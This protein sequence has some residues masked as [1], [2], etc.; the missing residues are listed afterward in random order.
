MR[1]NFKLSREIMW[2]YSR[3]MAAQTVTVTCTPGSDGVFTPD[4]CTVKE[5]SKGFIGSMFSGSRSAPVSAPNPLATTTASTSKG[6][7]GKK[8]SKSLFG[9]VFGSGSSTPGAS[10]TPKGKSGIGSFSLF[11]NKKSQQLVNEPNEDV[12]FGSVGS[13]PPRTPPKPESD[14]QSLFSS[15]GT[16]NTRDIALG[17]RPPSNVSGT[18]PLPVSAAT[19]KPT[20]PTATGKLPSAAPLSQEEAEKQTA[21]I[22]G[23]TFFAKPVTKGVSGK[24]TRRLPTPF[25]S[26]SNDEDEDEDANLLGSSSGISSGSSSRI[27]DG[28]R[29]T[30]KRNINKRK[31]RRQQKKH[32]RR[33]SR[34]VQH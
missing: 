33:K 22:K 28:G 11:G 4:G 18:N 32:P 8:Q 7:A 12:R 34:K 16:V 24:G 13:T 2:G 21:R 25:N 17:A 19:G 3:D 20:L 31:S 15:S 1:I 9:S 6:S 14:S 30:M 23:A 27:S 26:N 5:Q 10:S 29:R